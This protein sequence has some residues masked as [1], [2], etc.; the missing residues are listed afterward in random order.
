M[1]EP[2]VSRVEI[3]D[4]ADDDHIVFFVPHHLQLEFFPADDGFLDQDPCDG[5]DGQ[6][7]GDIL[8]EVLPVLDDVASCSAKSEG[9]ADHHRELDLLDDVHGF[10][11]A[12]RVSGLR[13]LKP[14]LLHGPAEEQPVLRL[15]D[16][17][18]VDSDQL[19]PVL[20][21]DPLF[22]ELKGQVEGFLAAQGG[23]QSV[24]LFFVDDLLQVF[25]GQG[26]QIS[27]VGELGIGHDRGRVGV[28]QYDFV[29]LFFQCLESL[30][31]GIIE[32]A[33]LPDDDRSGADDQDGMDVLAPRHLI[34]L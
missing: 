29:V 23:Q 14:D 10:F 32:F 21:Q 15:S 7:E 6:A 26:L 8:V 28:E 19:N 18:G 27:P 5:A 11:E 24:R 13:N 20:L 22:V 25:D 2:P 1:F 9:G 34:F 33:G 16:G 30:G 12:G 3:L 4:A 17:F 31:A